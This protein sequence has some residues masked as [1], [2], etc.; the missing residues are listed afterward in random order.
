MNLTLK[1]VALAFIAIFALA[2]WLLVDSYLGK[3][4]PY[5][6][7]GELNWWWAISGSVGSVV[8]ASVTAPFLV[9]LFE[10]RRWLAALVLLAPVL[11]VIDPSN[12]S[13]V[14]AFLAL[15]YFSLLMI[16]I[17]LSSRVLGSA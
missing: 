8:A 6:K 14:A 16:G 12:F 4:V 11:V 15:S 7:A 3:F 9:V 13:L 1:F 2:V 5:S 17:W 10:R